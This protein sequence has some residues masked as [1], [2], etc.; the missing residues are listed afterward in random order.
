MRRKR[1]REVERNFAAERRVYVVLFIKVRRV[2]NLCLALHWGGISW[3][4]GQ[5]NLYRL[6]IS[7][8]SVGGNDNNEDVC[9]ILM[10]RGRDF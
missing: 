3:D 4:R 2:T 10:I 1:R 9:L 8:E 6:R 5:N 7:L